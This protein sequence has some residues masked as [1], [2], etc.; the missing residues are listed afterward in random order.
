MADEALRALERVAARGDP[1]DRVAYARA[2]ERARGRDAALDELVPG[3]AALAVRHE[4][5]RFPAWTEQGGGPGGTWA[6]DTAPLLGP[7]RVRWR[8]PLPPRGPARLAPGWWSLAA[9]TPAASILTRRGELLVVDPEDGAPRW[10][11]TGLPLA[12]ESRFGRVV[13]DRGAVARCRLREVTWYDL[14]TGA[15]VEQRQFDGGCLRLAS[16]GGRTELVT[17][18]SPRQR[19]PQHLRLLERSPG[20]DLAPRW[21]RPLKALPMRPREVLLG[22]DVL[23]VLGG[24]RPAVGDTALLER[25]TGATRWSGHLGRNDGALDE[26]GAILW[27][28]GR[29]RA[30]DLDGTRRWSTTLETAVVRCAL[31]EGLVGASESRSLT[32]L[33]RATGRRLD[34]RA[35]SAGSEVAGAR[36]ALLGAGSH[37]DSLLFG[38]RPDGGLAWS[39]DLHEPFGWCIATHVAPLRGRLLV[40]L[41]LL[42]R[43]ELVCFEA[44]APP[45]ASAPP[46]GPGLRAADPPSSPAARAVS[47]R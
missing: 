46:A 30:V 4:L 37:R 19:G 43:E 44:D 36:G 26:R 34:R 47:P 8:C 5:E 29:V 14:V 9:A 31:T 2:V 28:Q 24:P 17:I 10:S 21:E 16:A 45:G 11:R 18:S 12:P 35:R 6:V 13:V 42:D 25:S 27:G 7:P 41:H 38:L 3:R 39:L 20:G 40:V 33:D 22:R 32:R 15:V 23:L 1:A